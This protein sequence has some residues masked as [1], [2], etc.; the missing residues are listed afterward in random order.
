MNKVGL[1]WEGAWEQ[2]GVS[3]SCS[4]FPPSHIC[5]INATSRPN[6]DERRG[7]V[8]K[9]NRATLK[10]LNICV[11]VLKCR[12]ERDDRCCVIHFPRAA[13]TNGSKA[14]SCSRSLKTSNNESLAKK[15]PTHL[16]I[17]P[18]ALFPYLIDL[19]GKPD[20]SPGSRWRRAVTYELVVKTARCSCV[21]EAR[22]G[23]GGGL[24]SLQC[25]SLGMRPIFDTSWPFPSQQ[26]GARAQSPPLS[27]L[28]L[29]H[30]LGFV[31]HD[32]CCPSFCC[33]ISSL[34]HWLGC[35]HPLSCDTCSFAE[36]GDFLGGG[37]TIN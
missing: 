28:A 10:F 15:N 24:L 37:E 22:S 33:L 21:S 14:A 23:E 2:M 35:L 30:K 29:H 27:F 4:L 25:L 32:T 9:I 12:S 5:A 20:A 1:M 3:K 17:T 18:E 16:L 31:L 11:K 7:R 26:L 13:S 36:K 8:P 6:V 34:S 19:P